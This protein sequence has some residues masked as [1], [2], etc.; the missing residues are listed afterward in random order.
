MVAVRHTVSRKGNL[1]MAPVG[2]FIIAG[3][4]LLAAAVTWRNPKRYYRDSRARS[5]SE[6]AKLGM[7]PDHLPIVSALLFVGAVIMLIRGLRG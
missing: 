5:D 4:L 7:F 2:F 1:G 3:V 6:L